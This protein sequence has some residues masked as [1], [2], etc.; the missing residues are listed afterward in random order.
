MTKKYNES[1]PDVL[2]SAFAFKIISFHL[3]GGTAGG[4]ADGGGRRRCRRLGRPAAAG[5]PTAPSKNSRSV[6][7]R[8]FFQPRTL[9][10]LVTKWNLP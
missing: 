5:R 4:A 7:F 9:M 3:A 6:H 2:V 10:E 8:S 1:L